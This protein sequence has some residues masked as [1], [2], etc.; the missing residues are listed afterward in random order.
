MQRLHNYKNRVKEELEKSLREEH[1]PRQTAFSAALGTFVTVIPT[2]G[3]GI[4][5]FIIITKMFKSINKIALFACVVVFNP[6]MKY[7]IYIISY[8]IG[9]FFQRF[10]PPDETLEKAFTT[11]AMDA[12]QTMLI[13]NLFLAFVLSIAAYLVVLKISETYEDKNLDIGEEI[14]DTLSND[15]L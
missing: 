13:G 2:L 11:Q 10:S 6:V 9:S 7:P 14:A 5:F 12:T 3:L 4:L 15:D 8:S 1:T